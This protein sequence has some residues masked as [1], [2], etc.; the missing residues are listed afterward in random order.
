M[1]FSISCC[2]EIK[3]LKIIVKVSPIGL[4]TSFRVH[5]GSHGIHIC[6]QDIIIIIVIK[7]FTINCNLTK[8]QHRPMSGAAVMCMFYN[9]VVTGSTVGGVTLTKALGQC[10]T[11]LCTASPTIYM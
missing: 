1:L 6:C 5:V 8:L 4:Q 9:Q 3:C 10:L 7:S 2:H 11:N